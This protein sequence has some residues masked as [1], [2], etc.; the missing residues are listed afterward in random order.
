VGIG[1][2]Y[3]RSWYIQNHITLP[4][5]FFGN[6]S[7]L[8]KSCLNLKNNKV[9]LPIELLSLTDECNEQNIILK[10]FTSTEKKWLFHHW[11]KF[12]WNKLGISS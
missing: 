5:Y 6:Y 12:W 1:H 10:L 4:I 3:V 7:G 8:G 11:K 9:T 2:G